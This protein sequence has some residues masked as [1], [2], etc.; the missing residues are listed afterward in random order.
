[1]LFLVSL[2]DVL[3]E[4]VQYYLGLLVSACYLYGSQQNLGLG[5]W[6]LEAWGKRLLR[7]VSHFQWK[8]VLPMQGMLSPDVQK[9]FGFQVCFLRKSCRL[10]LPTIHQ[11]SAVKL[12]RDVMSILLIYNIYI[13]VSWSIR[14]LLRICWRV[15]LQR[16]ILHHCAD[17]KNPQRT[18][19]P[20][21]FGPHLFM[22]LKCW[23]PITF[24]WFLLQFL[25]GTA[26]Q[27]NGKSITCKKTSNCKDQINLRTSQDFRM[28]EAPSSQQFH[29]RYLLQSFTK[30]CRHSQLHNS[31]VWTTTAPKRT[32]CNH[33]RVA[34]P[35]NP[36]QY[37]ILLN[38][39]ELAATATILASQAQRCVLPLKWCVL[40]HIPRA[41]LQRNLATL[42]APRCQHIGWTSAKKRS[43]KSRTRSLAKL[44]AARW[45]AYREIV[46]GRESFL[47]HTACW[48][49]HWGIWA[50]QTSMLGEEL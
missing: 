23:T 30:S 31:P 3:L 47:H 11:C 1:M 22:N 34:T 17:A 46:P 6:S 44:G 37:S 24:G 25:V 7:S 18:G 39:H 48:S 15:R 5:P 13:Y 12:P 14:N 8:T 19:L 26:Y 50:H 9:T 2:V 32:H 10:F 35:Q 49:S 20:S 16:R 40:H 42:F 27:E 21:C 45:R 36:L 43:S 41:S 38:P 4:F 28:K 33:G 29:A